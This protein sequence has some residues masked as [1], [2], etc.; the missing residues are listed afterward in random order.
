[1]PPERAPSMI[2]EYPIL[3]VVATCATGTTRMRGLGELRVKESDRLAAMAT[4][5]TACGATVMVEG[6]DLIVTG[7]GKPPKGGAQIAVHL[8]HRIG[9]SL[10]GAGHGDA[11]CRG[12]GRRQHHRHQFPRL[13]HADERAGCEDRPSGSMIIAIDGPAGVGKGTLAKQLAKHFGLRHLDTGALYRA[14]GRDVLT[15]G[16]DPQDAEAAVAA[17]RNLDASTLAD[18]QLRTEQ[19]GAAA[20]VVAVIPA[21]RTA[22]L[23]YQQD[24]ARVPP[25]AVLDGRDIGTVVCPDADAKL[26]ITASA[27]VRADRRWRELQAKGI[28]TPR[29][30]ILA[31]IKDRDDRDSKRATAPMVP[32]ADAVILDTSALDIDGAFR[33]ALKAVL[34]R[35]QKP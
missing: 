26:F 6:D 2:D 18:P 34:D 33:A 32:A 27:E 17:A 10:P 13:R 12:R 5:L 30:Q 15:A 16:R 22:L 21:V 25:G 11:R 19:V 1:M 29:D 7:T 35:R 24:F 20:S 8:D 28:A 9:M 23:R 3:S 14:V 31:E 4:G